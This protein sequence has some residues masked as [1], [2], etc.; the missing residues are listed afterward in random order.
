VRVSR[1]GNPPAIWATYSTVLGSPIGSTTGGTFRFSCSTAQAPCKVSLSAAVLSQT[2][3]GAHV[4]P[5]L[6]IFRQD[7]STG[8]VTNPEVYCEYADGANNAGAS[9][10]IDRVPL[11]TAVGS[12]NAPLNLGVGGSLDCGAGQPPSGVVQE[13]WVPGG[14]PADGGIAE[15]DVSATLTFA[16]S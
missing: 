10:S 15:Y 4:Y 13:I 11:D 2:T 9:D 6:L 16:Q 14:T 12:I 3:G 1:G 7:G 5:R 8:G